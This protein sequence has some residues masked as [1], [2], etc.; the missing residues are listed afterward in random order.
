MNYPPGK[1][2]PADWCRWQKGF[3]LLELLTVITIILILAA[4]LM[5]AVGIWKTHAEKIRC[6]GNLRSLHTATNSFVQE[7]GTWPQIDPGLFKSHKYDAA[8]IDAL[9]PYGLTNV[10][11]ICP[12]IQRELGNPDYTSTNGTRADYAATPFPNRQAPY[13]WPTQPWF[14]EKGDVH[15]SGN[16]MI[17][18]DGSI[19]D[20]A[21]VRRRSGMYN[22]NQ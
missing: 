22:I 19:E 9:R 16:L 3:T 10:N 13:R 14:I 7:V 17:F 8:W 1:C 20:L 15:G 5:P 2:R 21:S 18:Y 4:M 11:W 6:M 12:T